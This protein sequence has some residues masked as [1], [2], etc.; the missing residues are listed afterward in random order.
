M[1][2]TITKEGKGYKAD[3]SEL[4]GSPRCGTGKT[5]EEAVATLFIRQYFNLGILDMTYLEINGKPYEDI[6]KLD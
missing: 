1:K 2:I 6:Y 5:K 3:F 4:S